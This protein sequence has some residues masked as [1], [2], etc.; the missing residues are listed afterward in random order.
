MY[1]SSDEGKVLSCQNN[2]DTKITKLDLQYIQSRLQYIKHAGGKVG[3]TA[4]SLSIWCCR[5]NIVVFS[6]TDV[7]TED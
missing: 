3:S 2:Q 7:C 6:T 5:C 1:N 4:V